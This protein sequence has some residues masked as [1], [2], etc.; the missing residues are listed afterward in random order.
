MNDSGWVTGTVITNDGKLGMR[1]H[2]FLWNGTTTQDLWVGAGSAINDS[3]LVAGDSGIHVFLWNGTTVRD[4]GTLGGEAFFPNLGARAINASGQVTGTSLTAAGIPHAHAYLWNGTTMQDLGTLGGP[5]SWGYAINDS[6]QV[7]GAAS[8]ADG[9]QH[10]FLW[11]GTTMQ[12]LGPLGGGSF[13]YPSGAAPSGAYTRG[14][15]IN[16]SGQ[17]TGWA[18]HGRRRH[19]CIPVGWHRRCGISA[20]WEVRTPTVRRSTM[21]G[22]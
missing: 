13:P 18:T 10:A 14:N 19:P 2:A 8:L 3:G 4:L 12:D 7:T 20:R 5:T 15:A 17:V 9:T 11:N 6:G 21:R 1:A 22:R 16:A